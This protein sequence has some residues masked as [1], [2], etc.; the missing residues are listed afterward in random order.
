MLRYTKND[1]LFRINE[2]ILELQEKGMFLGKKRS[3]YFGYICI[4]MAFQK[5]M[6]P[7]SS[8]L[9]WKILWT[10]ESGRLQSMG[11]LRVRHD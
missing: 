8:A 3:Q 5:A 10:E 11:S 2:K 6:A 7:L 4:Y 9:A 1:R